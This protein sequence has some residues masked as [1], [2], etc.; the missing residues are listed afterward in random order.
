MR[1]RKD[2]RNHAILE[3]RRNGM[4]IKDIAKKYGLC[5][6]RTWTILQEQQDREE[7]VMHE[8]DHL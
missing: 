2:E 7:G 6:K 3:D 4:F 5:Y 8:D 1:A